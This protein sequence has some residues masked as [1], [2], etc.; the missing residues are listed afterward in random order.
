MVKGGCP[1]EHTVSMAGCPLTIFWACFEVVSHRGQSEHV[2]QQVYRQHRGCSLTWN[3]AGFHTHKHYI[4]QVTG[5]SV[6]V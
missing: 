3:S 1:A 4:T 6:C 2:R 5:T